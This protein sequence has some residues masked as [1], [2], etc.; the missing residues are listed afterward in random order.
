MVHINIAVFSLIKLEHTCV[1]FIVYIN[2][3]S[4]KPCHPCG[5][6]CPIQV[7]LSLKGQAYQTKYCLQVIWSEET[8]LLYKA[9]SSLLVLLKS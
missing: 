1:I 7:K 5:K 4:P 3:F 8:H 6:N 2:Y 9:K